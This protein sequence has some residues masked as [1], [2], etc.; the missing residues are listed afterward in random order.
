MVIYIADPPT[1]LYIWHLLLFPTINVI[2]YIMI[3]NFIQEKKLVW[4]GWCGRNGE[5]CWTQLMWTRENTGNSA[6]TAQFCGSFECYD[7]AIN[8]HIRILPK[9]WTC[10]YAWYVEMLAE[11]IWRWIGISE[12]TWEQENIFMHDMWKCW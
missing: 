1:D 9:N 3:G 11:V 7:L 6:S 5:T 8:R 12:K 4:G 2:L 10:F